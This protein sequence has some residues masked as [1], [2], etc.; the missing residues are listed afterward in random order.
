MRLQLQLTVPWQIKQNANANATCGMSVEETQLLLLLFVLNWRSRHTSSHGLVVDVHSEFIFS[1]CCHTL[2][3]IIIL[4]NLRIKHAIFAITCH[5]DASTRSLTAQLADILQQHQTL[6]DI[7]FT[8]TTR[9][10]RPKLLLL[11]LS[12]FHT[13][14][15]CYAKNAAYDFMIR[16][17]FT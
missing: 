15:K 2:A 16:Q 1:Y 7:E 3:I 12:S 9:L 5:K 17:K 14:F 11:A 4:F 6:V 8:L 13:A 10:L